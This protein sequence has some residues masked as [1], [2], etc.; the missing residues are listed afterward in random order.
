M[1][2]EISLELRQFIAQ[3]AN[4]RCEYC[5]LPQKATLF[6]HEPDHIVS[7]QHGGDNS[8]N[9]LALACTRCNRFKGPNVGSFDPETGILTPFFNPRS[10]EWQ[11]HFAFDDAIIL[12]LTP[13]AR[14]TLKI[15]R[16]N[17]PDRVKERETLIIAGLFA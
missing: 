7:R 1:S 12:A 14:V 3:R 2:S 11:D 13:E 4:G 5:Q 8:A 10:Q 16:I 6:K 15:L 17:D 9:N